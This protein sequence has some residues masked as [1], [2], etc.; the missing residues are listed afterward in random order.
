MNR[1]EEDFIETLMK[2]GDISRPDA[3][4]VF[5]YYLQHKLVKR[6]S[7]DKY[8]VKHGQFLD[9]ETIR[10]ALTLT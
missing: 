4:K 9:R 3:I 2:L 1:G 6:K 8:E 7:L 5:N 10:R